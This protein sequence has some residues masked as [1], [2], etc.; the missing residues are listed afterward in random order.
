[1]YRGYKGYRDY[2]G[3]SR[4]VFGIQSV[5]GLGF[6]LQGLG[7]LVGNGEWISTVVPT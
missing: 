5:L 3:I 4:D 7:L 2:T 1:M 6:R